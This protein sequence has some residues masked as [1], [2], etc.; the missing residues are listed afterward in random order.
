MWPCVNVCKLSRFSFQFF[1][2][3]G[4]VSKIEAVTFLFYFF[5]HHI[6]AH[7]VLIPLKRPGALHITKGVGWGAGV[8]G[9]EVRV[10]WSLKCSKPTTTNNL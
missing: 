5:T 10:I 1:H 6:P 9:G 4:S 7:T 8:G 2:F 3:N